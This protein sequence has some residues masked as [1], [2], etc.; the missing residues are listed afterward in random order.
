MTLTGSNYAAAQAAK[1]EAETSLAG[2]NARLTRWSRLRASSSSL[3]ELNDALGSA[4]AGE[5]GKQADKVDAGRN[6][7]PRTARRA[8]AGGYRGSRCTDRG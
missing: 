7:T 1:V 5:A 6:I 3:G 8:A 4:V 2:L